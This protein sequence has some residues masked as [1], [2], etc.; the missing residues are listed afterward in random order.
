M[1]FL[2]LQS[3][4]KSYDRK[5]VIKRIQHQPMKPVELS[6]FFTLLCHFCF[7]SCPGLFPFTFSKFHVIWWSWSWSHIRHVASWYFVQIIFISFAR[8]K[9]LIKWKYAMC[10]FRTG[11]LNNGPPKLFLLTL[12]FFTFANIVHGSLLITAHNFWKCVP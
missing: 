6:I 12:A 3:V 8:Q 7:F 2:A 1:V 11:T 9:L 4:T 10:S 5:T